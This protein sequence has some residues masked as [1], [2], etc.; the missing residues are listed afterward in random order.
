M[1]ELQG[2]ELVSPSDNESFA[3]VP[4]L[5]RRVKFRPLDSK[6][7]GALFNQAHDM[8]SFMQSWLQVNGTGDEDEHET[9]CEE[10]RRI[11]P[12]LW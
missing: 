7:Y 1:G 9:S 12:L 10:D 2:V 4:R 11:G 8:G 3:G 5:S 6:S